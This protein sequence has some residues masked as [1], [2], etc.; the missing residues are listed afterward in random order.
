MDTIRVEPSATLATRVRPPHLRRD[1]VS[2]PRLL[3]RLD[4]GAG[5][6]LT[7]V[8]A[9][10]GY[11]KTTLLAEWAASRAGPVAWLALAETDADPAV[12]RAEALASLG[13]IALDE[14]AALVLDGYERVAGTPAEGAITE[15]VRGRRA[16][17]QVVVVGRVEPRVLVRDALAIR[18]PELRMTDVEASELLHRALGGSLAVREVQRRIERCD[19]VPAALRAAAETGAEEPTDTLT[20]PELSLLR[21]LTGGFTSR[22]IAHVLELSPHAVDARTRTVYRKLGVSSRAGAVAR[23]HEFGVG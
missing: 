1:L 11:G 23:A 22:E 15:L 6:D 19:G 12:L 13:R 16:G 10:A 14:G 2:R 17:L 18:A 9:P 20:E 3:E 7:L 5:H 21:L 8:S 4:E